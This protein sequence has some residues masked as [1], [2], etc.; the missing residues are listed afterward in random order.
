MELW[1]EAGVFTRVAIIFG[2]IGSVWVAITA[3]LSTVDDRY[4][5]R[6]EHNRYRDSVAAAE[7]LHDLRDSARQENV[8]RALRYNACL[9]RMKGKEPPCA[10]LTTP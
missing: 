7:A 4:L 1:G 9:T 5:L 3:A 8:L 6:R 2:L 10:H